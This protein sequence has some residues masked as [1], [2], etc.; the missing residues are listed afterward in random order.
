MLVPELVS[1]RLQQLYTITHYW[2]L[3]EVFELKADLLTEYVL[4]LRLKAADFQMNGKK[5]RLKCY[6]LIL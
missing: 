3:Y 4:F 1:P 2:A 5:L 6:K